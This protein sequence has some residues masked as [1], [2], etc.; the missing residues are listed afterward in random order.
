[1]REMTRKFIKECDSVRDLAEQI[2]KINS[3]F[4]KPYYWHENKKDQEK[5]DDKKEESSGSE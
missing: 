2:I 1:M 3:G 5:D 4:C